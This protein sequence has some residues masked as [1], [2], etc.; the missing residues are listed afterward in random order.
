MAIPSSPAQVQYQ[1]AAD[2]V[3]TMTLRLRCDTS[4]ERLCACGSSTSWAWD[5]T[6]APQDSGVSLRLASTKQS[7]RLGQAAESAMCMHETSTP[8]PVPL[9]VHDCESPKRTDA[10]LAVAFS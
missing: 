3:R 8:E 10:E 9:Q 6:S 4:H 5:R 1:K 2:E 7:Q